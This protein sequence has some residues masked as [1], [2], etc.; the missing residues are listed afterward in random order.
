MCRLTFTTARSASYRRS[1]W[2]SSG[3]FCAIVLAIRNRISIVTLHLILHYTRWTPYKNVLLSNSSNITRITKQKSE[4]L[5]EI[6]NLDVLSEDLVLLDHADV[7]RILITPLAAKLKKPKTPKPDQ[8]KTPKPDT[9]R[10]PKSDPTKTPKSKTP[11]AADPMKT[12]KA[13]P[14][15][16]SEK[17]EIKTESIDTE[18]VIKKPCLT[19]DKELEHAKAIMKSIRQTRDSTG[20]LKFED[21]MQVT[22]FPIFLTSLKKEEL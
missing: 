22:K 15:K 18:P 6:P 19:E 11:R 8:A 17:A 7:K 16:L 1:S 9:T 10:T 3:N 12:P 2:Q 4:L 13:R 5:Q 20:K 14:K 21:F